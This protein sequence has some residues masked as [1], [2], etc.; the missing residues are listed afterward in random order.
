[1]ITSGDGVAMKNFH[2]TRATMQNVSLEVQRGMFF[3]FISN[4]KVSLP[5]AFTSW[6]STGYE[7]DIN[8]Q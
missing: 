3:F 8:L 5:D 4:L 2:S 1:L 6:I 7:K